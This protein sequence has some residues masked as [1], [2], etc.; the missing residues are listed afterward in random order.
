[1]GPSKSWHT[2]SQQ[3]ASRR[4]GEASSSTAQSSLLAT[5]R[6]DPWRS[7]RQLIKSDK[8]TNSTWALRKMRHGRG[9]HLSNTMR[10]WLELEAPAMEEQ[11]HMSETLRAHLDQPTMITTSECPLNHQDSNRRECQQ[12]KPCLT[13]SADNWM[14]CF[15]HHLAPISLSL[16]MNHL[17]DS[18]CPNLQCTMERATRLTSSCTS[19]NS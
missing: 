18:W 16:A 19:G 17:E 15:P 5:T 12:C 13:L 10:A 9:L 11:P 4:I 2:Q 7:L 6:G 3:I 1:M 8:D 14:T